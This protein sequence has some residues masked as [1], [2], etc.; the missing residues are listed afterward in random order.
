[1]PIEKT[2]LG[3]RVKIPY[4]ELVNLYGCEIGDG[5]FI[6]PFVE[7]QKGVK[8]GKGSRIQSHTFICSK[9]TIGRNV[10]VGHGV[11][12][13]NDKHPVNRNSKK[14][15]KTNIAERAVIGNNATILP[16]NIGRNALIGAGAV[17]TRDVKADE[18][19]AGNP[20]KVIGFKR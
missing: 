19:V 20:A 7:I 17:V 11:T 1:M 9:V 10:F 4:P 13:V 15:Q 2:R 18:I 6:G 3:K 8:V 12:F 14:W 5:C 16:S